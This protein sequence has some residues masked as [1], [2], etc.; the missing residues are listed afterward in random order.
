MKLNSELYHVSAWS[1]P[2]FLSLL[3]ILNCCFGKSTHFY[4][5]NMALFIFQSFSVLSL[6][7]SFLRTLFYFFAVVILLCS[8]SASFFLR[9]SLSFWCNG[10]AHI[11]S[12]H[13]ARIL[14][15]FL[16]LTSF[17]FPIFFFFLFFFYFIFLLFP[18]SL[19]MLIRR[20]LFSYISPSWR[21]LISP[22]TAAHGFCSFLIL[23]FSF[24]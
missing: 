6:W 10:K 4:Y 8:Y 14:E 24:L 15:Y 1:Q 13:L 5:I 20:C 16:P 17:S 3:T 18:F 11:S 7:K 12:V 23:P 9:G 19:S 21:V 22:P 2:L